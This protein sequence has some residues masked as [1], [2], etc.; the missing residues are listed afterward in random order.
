MRSNTGRID[1]NFSSGQIYIHEDVDLISSD[2]LILSGNSNIV[3][4]SPTNIYSEKEMIIT[5]PII[6]SGIRDLFLQSNGSIFIEQNVTGKGIIDI[7][8]NVDCVGFEGI[9]I[10]DSATVEAHTINIRG[11]FVKH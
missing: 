3:I 2:R 11:N 1:Y 9:S 7:S 6:V 10:Y 5:S 8:S 4:E